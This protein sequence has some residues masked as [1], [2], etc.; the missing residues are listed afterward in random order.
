MEFPVELKVRYHP[1]PRPGGRHRGPSPPSCARSCGASGPNRGVV[2]LQIT[3]E[4]N[5]T[6]SPDSSDGAYAGARDA[7]IQGVIAAK[8][9]ARRGLPGLAIFNWFY[10]TDP[11]TGTRSGPTSAS[12]A[13]AVGGR[14][15]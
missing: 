14:R 12:T 9:E 6:I 1:S 3:N 13:S 15:R 7:L 4:V 11:T 10:R 8:D 2:A 5:F